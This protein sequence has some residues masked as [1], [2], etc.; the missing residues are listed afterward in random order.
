MNTWGWN[1]TDEISWNGFIIGVGVEFVEKLKR[2][3]VSGAAFLR[4]DANSGYVSLSRSANG[5]VFLKREV[6]NENN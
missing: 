6:K 3:F 4:R 5:S 2:F 1:S